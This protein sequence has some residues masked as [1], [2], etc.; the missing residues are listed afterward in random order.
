[1]TVKGG[2]GLAGEAARCLP[3][4]LGSLERFFGERYPFS[5]LDL[6][7]LPDFFWGGMEN[8]GAIFFN[9]PSLLADSTTLTQSARSR[10]AG[11]MAH[12][13]SHMWFGDL[14]TMAWWDDMWLN[15]SF[16]SWLGDKTT[17]E[18]F[19]EFRTGIIQVN[20]ANSAMLTDASTT[21]HPIRRKVAPDDDIQGSFD[22]IGYSKGQ[23]VLGMFERWLGPEQ[24]RRGV[25]NYINAHRGGNAV[26]E[27]FLDALGKS[28]GVDVAGPL[29]T[30]LDQPGVPF[31]SVRPLGGDRVEIAQKRF[32]NYGLLDSVN[33]TWKVP[34]VIM[35]PNGKS[36]ATVKFLLTRQ[37]DTIS[38]PASTS[39]VWLHPNAGESGYYRWKIPKPLLDTLLGYAQSLLSVRERLGLLHNLYA[40][41]NAGD[42]AAGEYLHALDLTASDQNIL[43]VKGLLGGLEAVSGEFVE[44]SEELVAPFARFVRR[45]LSP[46]FQ[47]IGWKAVS[48]EDPLM[49]GCRSGIM[50]DLGLYAKDSAVISRADSLATAY[51]KNPSS[52]EPGLVG[53]VLWLTALHGDSARFA[54]YR[55]RFETA[56][57][58]QDRQRFLSLMG[59]FTD[60]LVFERGLNY[61]FSGEVKSSELYGYL[62]PFAYNQRRANRELFL[63]WLAKNR[64]EL[65]SKL[66][67]QSRYMVWMVAGISQDRD[68]RSAKIF[69]HLRNTDAGV[70]AEFQKM[71]VDHARCRALRAREGESVRAYLMQSATH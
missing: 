27:D 26:A 36:T 3:P 41:M 6:V 5:K 55:K 67:D 22:E 15:E 31:V 44:E 29:A 23:A 2:T 34:V 42:L 66:G 21:T 69:E 40:R 13:M 1:V 48:G 18:V 30:F 11:T 17:E 39:I 25:V 16:A 50:A 47:R 20:G 54:V 59:A 4:L 24:F 56:E 37:K 61:T 9:Q 43:V 19:P 7:A 32:M 62:F 45:L 53:T 10:I 8:A 70:A 49:S 33:R 63:G 51:L 64:D 12:E 38:L 68:E 60:S 57:D 71:L 46:P 65:A 52:V 28:A 35:Y 14:V 58:P